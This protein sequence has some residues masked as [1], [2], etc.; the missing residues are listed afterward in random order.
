M[1]KTSHPTGGLVYLSRLVEVWDDASALV[2]SIIFSADVGLILDMIERL[3][4]LA[5]EDKQ[6]VGCTYII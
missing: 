1:R 4:T 3:C 2:T 5:S 6:Y